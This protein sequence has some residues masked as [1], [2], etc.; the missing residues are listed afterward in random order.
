MKA[1]RIAA[2]TLLAI[3]TMGATECQHTDTVVLPEGPK[4]AAL[5]KTKDEQ[6]VDLTKQASDLK[7]ARAGEQ[8]E[9]AKAAS[10]IKGI[11][12]AKDYLDPSPPVEAI[13]AEGELGLTRLPPDDPA[14]TVKALE[15][16]V[17]IVTGQ[18]D[19]AL[20][21]YAEADTATKAARAQINAQDVEIAKR[22]QTIKTRETEIANLKTAADTERTQHAAD[23]KKALDGKDIEI[24]KI[25]ADFASKERATWVLWTRIAGLG[26]IIVGVVLLAVFKMITE[27]AG[28]A[29]GGVIIGLISIFIDWLTA[30]VWFPWMCGFILL[31]IL[32]AGAYAIYRMWK[33]HTLQAKTMSALQDLKDEA[34]TLGTDAWS[35]V[36]EHLDYRLGDKNS[37]WA[38]A[39]SQ[40]VVAL[41]LV[42]PKSEPVDTKSVPPTS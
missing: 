10:N 6:I 37:F 3:F 7:V 30:Q 20:K 28:L 38:K 29:A 34:T 22:D 16:V 40:A 32:A 31:G 9:A 13:K 42:N 12:K 21:R 35:K 18:R 2:L 24:A 19:E 1:L 23:V 17:L 33:A 25:K 5:G 15:R 36:A 11:L 4:A 27:G 14:E 41:G 26:L 8:A 39:Q